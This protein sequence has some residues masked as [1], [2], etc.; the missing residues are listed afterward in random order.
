MEERTLVI[1]LPSRRKLYYRHPRIVQRTKAWGESSD[2][3]Y[4][5]PG[6]DGA[7]AGKPKTGRATHGKGGHGF[8]ETTYGG[9][10]VENIVQAICRDLLAASMI[11][12]E[13]AKLPVVMHAHD[14]IVCE[15]PR[16]RAESS[17]NQLL[18]I[19]SA[20]PKWAEGFPIEVEGYVSTRYAK[21]PIPASPERK[22]RNGK[23]LA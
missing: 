4:D 12:C 6:H 2:I 10:L 1:E 22:A 14:E 20:P 18:E 11:A 19:M 16:E 21:K 5:A 7:T 17:L 23:V 9:K 3:V 15:V 8:A 13:R